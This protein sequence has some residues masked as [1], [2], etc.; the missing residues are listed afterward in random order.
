MIKI[1][2]AEDSTAD[3]MLLKLNLE[4]HYQ[5]AQLI[6]KENGES[7]LNFLTTAAIHDQPQLIVLDENLPGLK[8]RDILKKFRKTDVDSL[9]PVVLYTTA[10]LPPSEVEELQSLSAHYLRKPFQLDGYEVIIAKFKE[11]INKSH[12]YN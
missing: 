11:L 4:K 1:F 10:F 6:V 5:E 2:Y 8:G 9:I 12:K 7:A 3:I